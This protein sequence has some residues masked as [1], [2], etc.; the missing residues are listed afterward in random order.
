MLQKQNR[1]SIIRRKTNDVFFSSPL[2]DISVSNNSGETA[3][4]GFVVSKRVNKSAVV[5]NRTK[6]V[7][8]G[9]VKEILDKVISGKD[10]VIVAK[11]KL[12][13]NQKEEVENNLINAF[14]K[15]KI[16]K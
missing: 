10:V 13:F 11:R 5:R 6:R 9:A 2:F 8:A 1:L 3:K 16:L 7:L 15:T 4:F 14:N 12:S